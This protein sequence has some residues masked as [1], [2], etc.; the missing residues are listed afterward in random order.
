MFSIIILLTS[1]QCFELKE[2]AREVITANFSVVMETDDFMNLNVKQVMKWVS[3]DDVIVSAEEEVFKGIVK[4][5]SH[6]RSERQKNFAALLHEVRLIS[7]SQEFLF[8]ELIN[9]KLITTNIDSLNFLL[10][11][12][13]QIVRS[14]GESCGK[15][16]RK[17]LKVH[18]DTI[19]VCGG[20]SALCYLPDTNNWCQLMDMTL[21]HQD[22]AVV[23]YREKVHVFSRERH[24]SGESQVAEYYISSTDSWGAIQTKFHFDEQFSS[25][26]VLNGDQPLYALTNTETS[27]E[28]TLYKYD[29]DENTWDLESYE[30]LS[31]W[32]ACGVT[33]GR[34]IYIIGGTENESKE[35]NATSKVEKVIPIEPYAWEEVAHMTEARHDAFGTAMN[36]KIY[37]AGGQ[38]KNGQIC[39]VLKTCE[40]YSPSTDEWQIIPSLNVPRHSA[41]MVSFKGTLYVVGGL[42][43]KH[44]SREL[45]VEMFDSDANEWKKKSTI[46]VNHERKAGLKKGRYKACF[47]TIHKDAL[48]NKI[49]N[50]VLH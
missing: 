6:N 3:S 5:V 31:R 4:W 28:N 8:N 46:P 14:T 12:M 40:V 50:L 43:D 37:I 19:F 9:E 7:I 41:S 21:E 27:P 47:A 42:K 1:T 45:S 22:H 16:A 38:Q 20:R 44:R 49:I 48:N 23:Q 25:L 32:G 35:I 26:L 10:G 33:D 17:C 34:Y 29:P 18:K 11:S 15:P 24:V 39:T 2:G 13:K 36:G 30:T